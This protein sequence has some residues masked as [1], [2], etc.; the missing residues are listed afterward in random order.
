MKDTHPKIQ[1]KK[2]HRR[3]KKQPSEWAPDRTDD[4]TKDLYKHSKVAINITST[5]RK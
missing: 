3:K 2:M 1:I 5:R 4:T